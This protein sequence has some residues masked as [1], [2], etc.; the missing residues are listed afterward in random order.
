M[1]IYVG[2]LAYSTNDESL[3]EAFSPYGEVASARVVTDRMTGRSKGFGFV[4]M[5]DRT[6]A[7]AAIDA[8][9]GK[10]LDG[11]ALRVNES[12]PKPREE[13][14]GGG[15]GGGGGFGGGRGGRG[16]GGDRRERRETRW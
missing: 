10:D 1:D 11:R 15:G 9:N 14:R 4:E 6:Q 16:G 7:Q 3:K 2:N 8:L 13:R 5:P 12:Q